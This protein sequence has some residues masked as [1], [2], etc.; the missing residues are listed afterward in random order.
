MNP[1][2]HPLLDILRDRRSR[3][4]GLG[5]NIPGGPLAYTSRH[6]PVPLSEEAEATLAW[7]ACGITGPALA[8]LCYAPGH[9]GNIMAGLTGRT[10][11]SGDC[12]QTVGLVVIN[13]T[14]AWWMQRPQDLPLDEVRSLADLARRGEFTEA[15]KRC[16]VRLTEQRV[17]PPVEPIF[18]INANRWSLHAPG[19][20]Y[21]LPIG[22]LTPMYLN[23]LLEILNPDTG[24]FV[25]D[26]RRGYQPAG[27]A[28]F[29][30]SKGGHLDDDPRHGKLITIRQLEQFV[31]D[32][33]NLEMGMVLQNLG[34]ATQALGLGGFPH[35]ANHDFAWFQALG[36]TLQNL[37]ASRYLGTGPIVR[38][39]LRLL[40]KDVPVPLAT[41]LERDGHPLL[42]SLSPPNFP[43]MSEAVQSMVRRKFGPHGTFRGP[44]GTSAWRDH[45]ATA[46]GV[47]TLDERAI[48][49][50]TAYCEYVWKRYG[51][52][53][54]HVPPFRC[55]LAHQ[56]VHLDAEF[57]DRFYQPEALPAAQRSDFARTIPRR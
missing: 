5:M 6:A 50:T 51:R 36:F 19:S 47:P 8:D 54:V 21:F 16:R 17:H 41:R 1:A 25:V 18:N 11:A 13:D 29:A 31:T 30:R 48:A 49:A 45:R 27:L 34:L 32:F 37:P 14:G 35:F 39:G 43:T 2:Q 3:R 9:G 33:V 57:Y 20:T 23:G 40:G 53:P 55:G 56:A 24:V 15:W 42:I 46:D 7:A 4:F 44:N 12:L 28:R 38:L 26:E 22:D 10:V 52:F